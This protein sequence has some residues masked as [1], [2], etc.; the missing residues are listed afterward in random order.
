MKNLVFVLIILCTVFI[1]AQNPGMMNAS[2]TGTQTGDQATST[3]NTD[4]GQQTE[5]ATPAPTTTGQSPSAT[6]DFT[7]RLRYAGDRIIGFLPNLLAGLVIL[8][9][10]YIVAKVLAS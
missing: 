2:T 3:R 5:A 4:Q 1:L 9:V 10:G 7:D 8:L 6:S